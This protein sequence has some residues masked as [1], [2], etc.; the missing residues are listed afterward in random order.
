MPTYDYTC[1]NCEHTF[2]RLLR[3]DDRKIPTE[4]PC[5]NCGQNKI[6]SCLSAPSLVSPFRIDGLKKPS[7]QFKDRIS[8]I[9]SKLGKSGKNLKDY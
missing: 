3:I 6:E 1:L 7:P 2:E 9:K 8:Q 5:P 4:E